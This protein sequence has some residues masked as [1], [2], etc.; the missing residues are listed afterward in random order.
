[1][2]IWHVTGGERLRGSL[3]IQGSKNAVLPVIAAS[4]LCSSETELTNCP[5]LSDVE[6]A[7]DILRYLG[8]QAERDGDVLTIG[9]A[10]PSRCD[11]PRDL[12]HRMRSSVIFLG[13]MLARCGEAHVSVPGGC[14]LG[15]RPIDL[16]LQ[17]LRL[18]G[19]EIREEPGGI[20]CQ[21][22]RLR[23]AE[24]PLTL[25]SV[26][27]TENAMIAACAA[28]G[29]TVIY[30]AAREPE[31]ETLQE[32]LR[33][34]GAQIS[35]AGSPVIRV[36]GFTPREHAGLRIPPDRIAA[37]TYLCCT[38]C[39]GGDVDLLDAEPDH[40]APVLETLEAMGCA[41]TARPGHVH[42]GV[43]G[44]LR[45]PGA[46]VTRP[47]P[48][49]PTDAAPLLM[50]ACL[51]V[52]GP[53]VFIENIF[54]GRYRHAEE[55]RRLGADITIRGPLAMVTGVESLHGANLT[56]PDL[57][58]GAALVAAALGAE[59]PSLVYDDGHIRRGYDG[60]EE[61]LRGLGAQIWCE[62]GER[63]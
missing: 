8:C 57:R 63:Y 26:G 60:L 45:A 61:S 46:V 21:A 58:G 56:S 29:E 50:A 59:G 22:A 5:R 28:E 15:P 16:H 11:I 52:A 19:A 34:L 47:Y 38:A 18:L 48:G 55:L 33:L 17:A 7:M 39:A 13:P 44:R 35:G 10:S 2:S 4:L 43:S 37:A 53:A 27:A 36:N 31:I 1:M 24:I 12:M 25:P 32:Y 42:I 6:A 30:N 51:K 23:G 9:S 54:S 41:V 49:F 20:V 40:M 62:G 14:E 3:R